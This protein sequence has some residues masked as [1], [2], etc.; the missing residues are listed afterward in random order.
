MEIGYIGLGRMGS[1]MVENFLDHNVR[2]VAYDKA[3][4]L[5]TALMDK[6]KDDVASGLLKGADSIEAVASN[7]RM[8]RTVWLMI[9]AGKTVDMVL[10]QLFQYISVG[11]LI[12]EGGN[13]YFKDSIRRAKEMKDEGIEYLDIGT[14]GGTVGARHGTCLTIGG[15]KDVYERAEPLLIAA[16]NGKGMMYVG[17]SGAGHFAKMVHNFIEYGMEQAMCEGAALMKEGLEKLFKQQN[18]D[19]IGLCDAWNN[20]SIIQSRL[21]EEMA[22]AFKLYPGLEQLTSSIGGGESGEQA[23][24]TAMELKVPMPCCTAA[25][26]ER[27]RSRAGDNSYVGRAISAMRNSF[28]GHEI[29]KRE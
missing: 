16:S 19:L 1:N 22:S 14:S 9:P 24:N 23:L 29:K 2:V 18:P 13:S 6:R 17:P 12:I 8:P 3:S 10:S 5:V 28:G 27:Y 26:L 4:D 11:D 15:K 7:L 21:M 25:L 20:G